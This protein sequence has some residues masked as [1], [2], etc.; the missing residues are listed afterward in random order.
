MQQLVI[1]FPLPETYPGSA[2][3]EKLVALEDALERDANDAYEV[4]GHDAG[5]GEMNI[6]I[7]T[8]DAISTFRLIQDKL[9]G[10]IGWRAGFRDLDSD[11]YTPL[12]PPGLAIFKIQ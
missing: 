10:E 5:A 7:L 12:A 11:E 6:F 2:D 4:D 1:Q 3:F 8:D 9:A